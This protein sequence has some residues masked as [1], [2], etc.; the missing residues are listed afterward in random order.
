M[1]R[2]GSGIGEHHGPRHAGVGHPAPQFAIDEIG[3]AAEEQA[4][5]HHAA[6]QI[7]EFQQIDLVAAAIEDQRGDDAERA[8][9]E[10][11]AA[12]PQIE[13]V[14]RIGEI[15][16]WLVE[17]HIAEPSAEHRAERRPHQEI[18]D[19]QRGDPGVR[20]GRQPAQI[21][22]SAGQAGDIGQGVPAD[23]DRTETQR[24]RIDVGK[25]Q[26]H[27]RYRSGRER[28]PLT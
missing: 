24:D 14:D 6:Q 16:R 10:G 26:S 28:K 1:A 27:Q 20:L 5:R 3:D 9:M 7:A 23:D 21:A 22:P 25:L 4:E 11:H 15:E 18:V 13:D 2:L 8:A 19:L 17:Q 12:L